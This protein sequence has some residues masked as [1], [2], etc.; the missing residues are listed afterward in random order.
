[1]ATA[2][3]KDAIAMLKADHRKVEDLFEKYQ[4]ARGSERKRKLALSL[5]AELKIHSLLEEEIFYPAFKE[6]IE[7]DA[8]EEAQVEHDGTKVLINDLVKGD[9]GQEYYDAK[10]T[11]LSELVKHHVKEE[12]KGGS[13]IFAQCKK[14]EVDLVELRNQMMARKK[15][16]LAEQKSTGLPAAVPK[17]VGVL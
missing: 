15:E 16:L 5:C 10:V 3:F 17:A 9:P 12:E 14:T 7:D 4:S 13:G 11:V 8:L 1:M 2:Q 6:Q